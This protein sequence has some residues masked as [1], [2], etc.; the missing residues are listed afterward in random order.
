MK[1]LSATARLRTW[2]AIDRK[3][4]AHNYR[5]FRKV[6]G[7]GKKLMAVVKS[8]AYGHNIMEFGKEMEQLGAD[9]LGVDSITEG[10]SLRREGVKIPILVLGHTL[11]IRYPEARKAGI[12]ITISSFD[13]LEAALA[14][15]SGKNPLRVH[16]KVD[17]GM[18]RQGFQSDEMMRVLDTLRKEKGQMIVDGIYTHF[19]EAKNPRFGMTTRAQIVR[20]Q[21]WVTALRKAGFR[22]TAHAGATGGT[23]LYPDGHFGMA[24]VG[25]GLYG[26]WPSDETRL[27]LE[28]KLELKAVLTW[29][30]I[31]AEVKKIRSGE[32]IGYDLTESTPHD[33]TIAIL[34]IGYWHGFPRLLS[35]KGR[36][37]IGGKSAKVLGRVS[38]DMLIVD[39]TN[40]P[41]VKPGDEVVLIGKQGKETIPAAELAKLS[42]TT[43][44][45]IVTRLNP[46]ME[47][48]YI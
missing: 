29:K 28:K 45:E 22:A 30:T 36:V 14:Q 15:K 21:D 31:V 16:I 7:R 23:L 32:K 5:L 39:V 8:N 3:A 40:I 26:L 2:I 27:H 37:L 47:R 10:L 9:M 13:G 12:A 44:Y 1:K 33:A 34:P 42:G 6:I 38:M 35:S 11:P 46:L 18:H 24:R 43:H 4:I 20:F 17:T 48:I 19:A 41:K 25:I